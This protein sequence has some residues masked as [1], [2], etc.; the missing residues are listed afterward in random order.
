MAQMWL[1]RLS[2]LAKRILPEAIWGPLR[3]SATGILTPLR[4]SL[5][6]GHW[7]SSITAKACNAAGESLPWYTYL[8]IDFL[9]QRD[10]SARNILE[11]GGGQSTLWWSARAAS[12]LTIVEDREWASRLLTQIGQN[13][14]LYHVPV[15][16]KTRT[17][18]PIDTILRANSVRHQAP[19]MP[20]S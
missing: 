17:L 7:K 10:F 4:F 8:A 19:R 13:V 2:M 11:F 16:E 1:Q 6:T 9:A 20:E 3:S 18:A 15:N 14:M 5:T 12:V